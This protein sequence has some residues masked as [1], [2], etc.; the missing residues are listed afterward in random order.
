[1]IIENLKIRDNNYLENMFKVI[2]YH[3]DH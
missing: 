3:V 2:A 1:M